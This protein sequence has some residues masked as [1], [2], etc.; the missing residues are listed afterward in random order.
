M[1]G[2]G[3]AWLSNV[4]SQDVASVFVCT[5][6]R[7]LDITTQDAMAF[8]N[9]HAVYKQYNGVVLVAD[10]G[11]AIAKVLDNKKAALLL[12]GELLKCGE[13]RSGSG[14]ISQD[15]ASPSAPPYT[16]LG[17]VS[18]VGPCCLWLADPQI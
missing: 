1:R 16:S 6:G 11:Q 5:L 12:N 8:H 17:M 15:W 9:G 2:A 10:K 18:A 7:P 14:V 3:G 13:R 4:I